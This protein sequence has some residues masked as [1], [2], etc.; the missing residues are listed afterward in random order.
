MD[1]VIPAITG[2]CCWVSNIKCISLYITYICMCNQLFNCPVAQTYSRW[3]LQL[4]CWFLWESSLKTFYGENSVGLIWIHASCTDQNMLQIF[5]LSLEA[6]T[7]LKNNNFHIF[8]GS[9]V[10]II[11][12]KNKWQFFCH[13]VTVEDDSACVEINMEQEISNQ[14][15]CSLRSRE[16][17]ED[18]LGA[19][20]SG[21][22]S[23]FSVYKMLTF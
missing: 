18:W 9:R 11:S 5:C 13:F 16:K 19:L 7:K 2:I 21:I 1:F 8:K 17:N 20:K 15:V 10:F 6:K 14:N 3:D 4:M 22:S 12:L 23:Y